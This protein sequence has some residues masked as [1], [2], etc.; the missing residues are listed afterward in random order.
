ML[1]MATRRAPSTSWWQT[2]VTGA[3]RHAYWQTSVGVAIMIAAVGLPIASLEYAK[4]TKALRRK[5][6]E[7]TRKESLQRKIY[8]GV[9]RRKEK[10]TE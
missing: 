1:R 9:E 4:I 7:L 6:G 2:A 3:K 8:E 10:K 5:R